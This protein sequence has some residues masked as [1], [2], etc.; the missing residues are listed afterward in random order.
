VP[1]RK[2]F[3]ISDEQVSHFKTFGFVIFREFF[4]PQEV[5]TLH[6]EFQY[7]ADVAAKHEAHDGSKRHR[8][9]MMSDDTPFF[10]S[11][12]EDERLLATAERLIGRVVGAMI[13]G[14]RHA[15]PTVWHFDSSSFEEVG[16]KFAAYLQPLR[17]DTGALRVIPGSH[18]RPLFDALENMEGVGPRW[19]RAAATPEETHVAIETIDRVPG[20]ACESNPGDVV[21]FDHRTY[22]SSLGGTGDRWMCTVVYYKYPETPEQRELLINLAPAYSKPRD[23]STEP[24]NPPDAYPQD[25]IDSFSSRHLRRQWLDDWRELSESPAGK[26]GLNIKVKNG[27]LKLVSA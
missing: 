7:R 25:W 16:I 6:S 2:P 20:Y 19:S 3:S 1:A 8:L 11:L 15:G 10:A 21:L 13:D 17:A 9:C 4:N 27:K 18:H 12:L 22:H 26:N 24:W 23:N 5:E 14:D